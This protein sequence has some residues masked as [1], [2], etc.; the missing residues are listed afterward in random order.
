MKEISYVSYVLIKI[1]TFHAVLLSCR[2]YKM[3]LQM[4][5]QSTRPSPNTLNP[6]LQRLCGTS[7]ILLHFKFNF[8]DFGVVSSL[9]SLKGKLTRWKNKRDSCLLRLSGDMKAVRVIRVVHICY[10]LPEM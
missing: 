1:K 7:F 9:C 4:E 3:I 8:K 5:G 6:S 10:L 2:L